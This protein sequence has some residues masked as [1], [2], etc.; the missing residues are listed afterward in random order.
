MIDDALSYDVKPGALLIAPPDATAAAEAIALAG[1]RIQQHNSWADAAAAVARPLQFDLLVL[2]ATG[3]AADV[4]DETL[5]LLD[6]QAQRH[7]ARIVVALDVAQIDTVSTH[8]FGRH[9]QLLC[10]PSTRERVAALTLAG[11]MRLDAAVG[12]IGGDAEAARLRRLNEE[13]ARIAE[14]LARLT[15]ED[16]LP[17]R[18]GPSVGDRR[19]GY[20]APPAGDVVGPHDLRQAIRARRLRGQFFDPTL[21]EDPAWDMLLDL[22]AAELERAQVSV[23]SLCIAASVAPTTALRWIAKMTDAGL[24]ERHPDPF[25]RRRAFMALSGNARDGMRGYFAATRRAGLT[26]A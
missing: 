24:L 26:I 10:Q 13:V 6:H 9:V 5:P 7:G 17:E 21:L 11:A 25:D 19:N 23:S 14:T 12:E 1:A 2:E 22:Y 4:L 20:G 15:R 18:P 3:V 16:G 8:L